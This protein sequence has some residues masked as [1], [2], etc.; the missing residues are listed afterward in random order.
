MCL[1]VVDTRRARWKVKPDRATT[2][3]RK[4][5]PIESDD[6]KSRFSEVRFPA[7]NADFGGDSRIL[8]L[9][10]AENPGGLTGWRG[11]QNSNP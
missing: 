10:V 1:K 9:D 4:L 7:V 11:E 2:T 8:A 6:K 3:R 5:G